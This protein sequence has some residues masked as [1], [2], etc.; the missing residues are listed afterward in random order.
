MSLYNSLFKNFCKISTF[1]LNITNVRGQ[2]IYNWLFELIYMNQNWDDEEVINK[3]KILV[4]MVH[5][6]TVWHKSHIYI[7]C[8]TKMYTFKC[9]Y[10][11]L[12]GG[13]SVWVS[14]GRHQ[15]HQWPRYC[16]CPLH[17]IDDAKLCIIICLH[18]YVTA[19]A[20]T[21]THFSHSQRLIIAYII[22]WTIH[23]II[24]QF[25]IYMIIIC[26]SKFMWI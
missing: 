15:G 9:N 17:S 26:L 1:I 11:Q 7:G 4:K 25:R 20:H 24:M 12:Q 23:I 14:R 8:C 22:N 19:V 16:V 3:M 10:L 13:V 18:L 2:I 5:S 21:L 6:D